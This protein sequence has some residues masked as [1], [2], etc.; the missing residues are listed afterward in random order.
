MRKDATL[1]ELIETLEKEKKLLKTNIKRSVREGDFLSAHKYSKGLSEVR[2]TLGVLYHFRN[3]NKERLDMLFRQKRILEEHI[4]KYKKNKKGTLYFSH[5]LN[6]VVRQLNELAATELKPFEDSQHIDDAI[7][8]VVDGVITSFQLVFIGQ[9]ISINFQS[10]PNN[11]LEMSIGPT[12]AVYEG[13]LVSK[14]HIR[15]LEKLGFQLDSETDRYVYHYDLSTF[16][17]ALFIKTLLARVIYDAFVRWYPY[18][19]PNVE[20]HRLVDHTD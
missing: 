3:P 14:K 19:T 2:S 6:D 9:N 4:D 11:F 10:R 13:F 8:D 1:D 18:E 20:L 16:K 12:N 15:A 5:E 17:D 7:F